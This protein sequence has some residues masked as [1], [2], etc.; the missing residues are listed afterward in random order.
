M[1]SADTT[2]DF[3][4]FAGPAITLG[5]PSTEPQREVW[6]ACQMGREGSLAFN[7]AA[8]LRLRGAVQ[9]DALCAAVG[10]LV[11]RH[12]ALRSTFSR[13]GLTMLVG[14][15]RRDVVTVLDL[16]TLDSAIR[17]ERRVA[18][19]KNVVTEEFDLELGPL[20]RFVVVRLSDVDV[21]LVIAAHHI[22]CDGWSFG[23]LASDLAALYNAQRS[24]APACL[25]AA[26]AFSA[27]ARD[28]AAAAVSGARRED[29]AYWLAR[30]SGT[31]PVLDLPAD[32]VHPAM[33][34]FGAGREDRL[35]PAEVAG[36]VRAAG[37]RAGSSVFVTLLTAFATLV[38]RFSGQDDIVIGVPAA[39][40]SA[41]AKP[42]LVGHCVNM[43][44]IRIAAD[45]ARPFDRMLAEVR[46][47]TLDAFEHQ[48]MGFG[49]LLARLPI[50][51]DPS[52]SPLVSVIF[53]LDRSLPPSAM[54]FDGLEADLRT[55]P[56]A[57]ENFEL[58]LNAIE[59]DGG[60]ALECQYNTALFD[61]TTIR[62][63]LESYEV[64]LRG[65]AAAPS[66]PT[67]DL[68]VLTASDAAILDRCNDTAMALPPVR[69]VHRLVEAQVMQTP[70]A[71]AVTFEGQSLSYA[72]LDRRANRLAH[73]LRAAGAGRDRLVGLCLDRSPDLLVGLLA[74]LKCG[75]GYVPL[76]PNYP[77]DRL[78]FMATDAAL[79]ALVT[80]THLAG[81]LHRL[82]PVVVR[83]DADADA[84][85]ARPAT[86]LEPSPSDAGPDDTAYVIYT[87]G[88]TGRPKGVLVPHRAVVNLLASVRRE[89]GLSASDVMLAITTLSFDIAV[90]EVL[91]PLT[92]GARIVLA[93]RETATDGSALLQLIEASGVTVIDATPATY[94]LLLADGW[95]GS[96]SLRLIC[97]G[98]AMPRDLA[99]VLTGCARE[100]WNGYGPTETTVWSTFARI[101][102]PVDR[103]LIGR[104]VANTQV[105]ILDARGHQ[106]PVGV[107]GELLIAGEG[108]SRGYLNR[109]DLTRERFIAMP[110][111][112]GRCR[113]RTGDLVR[114]L[115]TGELECLGRND[116]QV[117]V[118][119][120]RI[121]PGEIESVIAQW[122]GVESA[123]V[124]AREDREG[125]VRLVAYVVA[126]A[127]QV[128]ADGLRAHV[129]A[130][131]PEYMIP[132][133]F[134]TLPSLPLTPSGKVDRK[135][136][137]APDA[138]A[139]VGHERAFVEPRTASEA[140]VA[141][142]WADALGLDRVSV[143]DD[144]FALGGHSLLASQVLSRL[145][146]DHGVLVP[147]RQVFESPTVEAFAATVDAVQATGDTASSPAHD[148]IPHRAGAQDA[149]LSV[150]QERLWM[151]EELQPGQ[152]AAHAHSAAWI[153]TGALDLDR[154]QRALSALAQRH[155]VL[156]TSFRLV[157]GERRQ[158]VAATGRLVL[159]IRDLSHLDAA[160]Q[161][162]ALQAFFHEQQHAPFDVGTDPLFRAVVLRLG[163]SSHMLYTLQHGMIWDGW[164]FDLFL[165]DLA[166]LYAA[167]EAG[168]A[169]AL[170][171]LPVTYGDFAAWQSGWMDGAEA[172]R[173]A[174]WWRS[175]LGG[176]LHE[177][178]LATD[179]ARP[180]VSSHGGAQAT[181]AFTAGE[182]EQLR[183]LA[184][185]HDATLFMVVFAAYNVLLHRYSGQRDLLVGSPVRARTRPE[186]E[187]V[188]GPFVN[189]VLLRTQLDPAQRFTDVL[190]A[191]RD[192]TLDAFSNQELPFER[193]DTR[194]PPL[195]VLFSMQDARERP[196]RMGTLGL[197]QYHV[198]QH[199]AMNDMMLW[200]MESREKLIA[201]L[202]YSTELFEPASA[203][204][205]LAQLQALLR[206]IIAAPD[207]TI[208]S[209]DLSS[210]AQSGEASVPAVPAPAARSVVAAIRWWASQD[211]ARV[212][213]RDG[214]EFCTYGEL[215]ARAQRVA[216]H[217]AHRG[218]G[219]GRAV[220]IAV[221]RGIDRSALLI[222][223]LWAGCPVLC[224]DGD[225]AS[226]SSAAA[227]QR[228]D[229][230]ACIAEGERSAGAGVAVLR[231]ET[232]LHADA[233][234]GEPDDRSACASV[235]SG[236]PDDDGTAYPARRTQHDLALAVAAAG[237]VMGLQRDD[238][239]L[240]ML[241]AA[242]PLATV[243]VFL[244]L[245][246]GGALVFA[247]DDA[248]EEPLDLGDEL[249]EV[250]ATVMFATEDTWRGLLETTWQAPDR[251]AALLVSGGPA[252]AAQLRT[253]ASR[254]SSAWT[255]LADGSAMGRI[256]PGDD[257]SV[258]E[259]GLGGAFRVVD[260]SGVAVP[261]GVPGV[262]QGTGGAA[263]A[264]PSWRARHTAGGRVHLLAADADWIWMEGVQV[265][266][267]AVERAIAGHAAVADAAVAV[268]RDA[269]GNRRLVG[270]VVPV[271]GRHVTETELR[272]AV[273]ARLPRRCIPHRF[274]EVAAI[275]RRVDGRVIRDALGSPFAPSATDHASGAPRT[276]TEVL[277][278][279][280]WRA[281]LE[282]EQVAVGDNF[283]HLGGTSL[284]CFRVIEQVRRA[285]GRVLNP[286]SLL[287]GTLGQVAAELDRDAPTPADAPAP[288]GGVLSRIRELARGIG[289]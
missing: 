275:P 63:W 154:L 160:T 75:A 126:A 192:V 53:N 3:D 2:A 17:H 134:I 200:M 143:H 202:N 279:S 150:L 173:Q 48:A 217:L 243:E 256:L 266:A 40:Q 280:Q 106:V 90:S 89:P 241:P 142:L 42:G 176:E 172:A 113:Y 123:V 141:S 219:P 223:A 29:E 9:V 270:Y 37:A 96:G 55:V 26:E 15:A 27:H 8:T 218:Y 263:E 209:F 228:S 235:I 1:I 170:A 61:A 85:A 120:F 38:H 271:P 288:V 242:A 108:V 282:L 165:Q 104:P 14:E 284:L 114:L 103:V 230:V 16:S 276:A 11:A 212:A 95:R 62:R 287:V 41:M 71:V 175:R 268:H 115:A 65:A 232:L 227:M 206:G 184:R 86:P 229:A 197:E 260:G 166:G 32:R 101:T 148:A 110:E 24:G 74:I 145:R 70:A 289:D 140:I 167:D 159:G 254:A 250:A 31:L 119:G 43:L 44:P 285:T 23:V 100:V 155:A 193:L 203:D 25:P 187:P 28:A 251:F 91:L 124:V 21:E 13:D 195:R 208:L 157:N 216:S 169:T 151:L 162:A 34:T 129:R 259:H 185:R 66:S 50:P 152:R 7:E 79:S 68:P 94:R 277:L 105:R 179:H 133:L 267:A 22:V 264:Q 178:A 161:D 136:L 248:R 144:F 194:V 226:E 112:P 207:A 93:S 261:R 201:V 77:S 220:A 182:A 51:R 67:G 88:S 286:R 60:I 139:D 236:A 190:A 233:T 138:A 80:E 107:P 211:P 76:D 73:H 4:P 247:S 39:G 132:N 12:E 183:A 255:L 213:V 56:R 128:V 249:A 205:F 19:L 137:P 164:S 33:R 117:K 46:S 125:D 269:R 177:L 253:L 78:Q 64:L 118:R 221:S 171:P 111:T 45:P 99:Q 116:N 57:F 272:A 222:G 238:V 35:I 180:A 265:R 214:R 231:A 245:V 83:I 47:T 240:A 153:L 52:R 98:E 224:L 10:A 273:R 131:L 163:P 109:P 198:P 258:V 6:T 122:P 5:V 127:E 283:F 225:D 252:D 156:R 102:A 188:I 49:S 87:S 135:S 147:F 210:P 189:T 246:H 244:P 191:V 36:A 121:E 174:A 58:F 237:E 82:A 97:T 181:L 274:A 84:I 72:E 281:V 69:L 257:T 54:P 262:L 204:L 196:V 168:R 20:A 130:A 30:F 239:V 234:P 59:T 158:V 92:V 149:P 146:R 199:F 186:L 81:D 278:A 18:L 215:V